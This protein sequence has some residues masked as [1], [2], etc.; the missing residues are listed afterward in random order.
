MTSPH[1]WAALTPD[2][3]ED[4]CLRVVTLPIRSTSTVSWI[5]RSTSVTAEHSVRGVFV[6]TV[7]VIRPPDVV[8]KGLTKCCCAVFATRPIISRPRSGSVTS[9]LYQ[10]LESR[11]SLRK[12]AHLSGILR[13]SEIW[14]K[15]STPVVLEPRTAGF[16]ME[17][18]VLNLNKVWKHR[19]MSSPNTQLRR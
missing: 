18:H 10:R 13:M 12:F 9:R 7:P 1:L 6:I 16:E 19:C 17:Q 4:S 5:R 15:C 3:F 14:P 11:Y 2:F 8:D